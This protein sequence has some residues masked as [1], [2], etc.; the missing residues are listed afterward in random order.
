M[1]DEQYVGE[2]NLQLH[3]KLNLLFLTDWPVIA[4]IVC[5][6]AAVTYWCRQ[7]VNARALAVI[8]YLLSVHSDYLC[9][10]AEVWIEKK[11]SCHYMHIKLLVLLLMTDWPDSELESMHT[12]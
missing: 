9:A 8:C 12:F 7:L 3:V 6:S 11:K 10:W 4:S 2:K 1:K 5:C